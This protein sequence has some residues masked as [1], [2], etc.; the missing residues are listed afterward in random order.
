MVDLT[1]EPVRPDRWKGTPETLYH[2]CSASTFQLIISNRKV[3][4][5]DLT[6]SNDSAEGE[7]Y[8]KVLGSLFEGT[9]LPAWF[10]STREHHAAWNLQ[11]VTL[12]LC[13]SEEGDL[14]SQ[15]RG[16]ADDGRGFSIG[17]RPSL[18]DTLHGPGLYKAIYS[19]VEQMEVAGWARQMQQ[20]RRLTDNIIENSTFFQFAFKNSG[21]QEEREWRLI[22]AEDRSDCEYGARGNRIVPYR[23]LDISPNA[24]C[25]VTLGPRHSTPL[26][27]IEGMLRR[28]GIMD[29][30]VR[31]AT[32]TYR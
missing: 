20:F 25:T 15:W 2:Y 27:V 26:P 7:W 21:F 4:L 8:W 19:P 30:E 9:E 29:V 32:A 5:S 10:T 12:G 1:H 24:I 23:D 28:Y 14:L 3:R 6:Q 31:S 13:L 11:R 18:L 22:S 16:Y 17:F